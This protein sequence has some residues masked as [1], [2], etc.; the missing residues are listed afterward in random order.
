MEQW[1]H[2]LILEGL[3]K[4]LCLSLERQPSVEIVSGTAMAWEEAIWPGRAWD[5]ERDTPRIRAAFRGLIRT[6]LT[7]PPPAKFFEVFPR[8]EEITRPRLTAVAT[9]ET[10]I[11][12]LQDIDAILARTVES[13]PDLAERMAEAKKAEDEKAA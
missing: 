6:C 11:K 9:E 2:N 5:E 8:F 7:W 10:R 4:L 12:H 13:N 3:Q 1:F